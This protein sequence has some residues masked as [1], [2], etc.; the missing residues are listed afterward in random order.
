[1][2]PIC[3]RNA[4]ARRRSPR[5]CQDEE[6]LT[7]DDRTV[8]EGTLR[9][10]I[11]DTANLTCSFVISLLIARLVSLI[12]NDKGALMLTDASDALNFLK[13]KILLLE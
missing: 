9:R 5:R 6:N 11:C 8:D 3:A 7:N 2:T 10:L 1:M 13:A 12:I 4:G